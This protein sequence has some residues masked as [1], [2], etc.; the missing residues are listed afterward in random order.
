MCINKIDV[1]SDFDEIKIC[2]AY[3]Y[4]KDILDCFFSWNNLDVNEIQPVYRTMKGWSE[5]IK[6]VTEISDLPK[7]AL[8][9]IEFI[10]DSLMIPVTMVGTGPYDRDIIEF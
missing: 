3:R 10:Q 9:Y 6:G 2:V 5:N 7:E 1:L 4:K 8:D